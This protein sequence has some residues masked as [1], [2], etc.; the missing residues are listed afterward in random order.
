M[1]RAKRET[2][3]RRILSF[4]RYMHIDDPATLRDDLYKSWHALHIFGRIYVSTEGYNA[5][6]SV[7]EHNWEEFE[8]NIRQFPVFKDVFFN[9]AVE[10]KPFAFFK[11]D[12]RNRKRL[13]VDGLPD[14]FMETAT[15]GPHLEPHQFHEMVGQKDVVVVDARN[16]YE[17][18]IGHFENAIKPTSKTFSK[19]LPELKEKLQDMKSKKIIMYCTGGIRCEKASAY[20]K[21]DG[22]ENVFQLKN[23]IVNYLRHVK[24]NQ[25]DSKFKGSNYV[26][27]ER[28]AEG[29]NAEKLAS[30]Q[31]CNTPHQIHSNCGHI[32]CHILMVQCPSCAEKF[33]GCCSESCIEQKNK[34]ESKSNS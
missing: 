22:F 18:L 21:K 10:P 12:I 9:F 32:H 28:M 6:M 16:G 34:I 3:P 27:D 15:P 29:T 30:C 1:E 24:E 7:P 13:V 4:Y 20:L 8:T 11:L 26:F 2:F 19:V 23:G 14:G 25:I 31:H 5:Q 17:C 33:D